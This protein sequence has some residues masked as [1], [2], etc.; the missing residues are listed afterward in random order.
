MIFFFQTP[1]NSIIATGVD[2]ALSADEIDRL[3]WLY[4][5][6][7]LC[8]ETKIDGWWV[9]PRREMITPWSTNAVEITQNMNLE[10]IAR[11][12]E[13]FPVADG[14]AD[15]DPMLQR[16]YEGLDQEIFTINRQPAK[17][18]TIDNL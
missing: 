13:F 17:I 9:G 2:H 4:G 1:A 10:G 16:L 15:H 12:E 7:T 8:P 5:Q 14:N 3:S 18:Q 11:I 6:A